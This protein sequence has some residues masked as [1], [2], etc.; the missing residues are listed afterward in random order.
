[1]GRSLTIV[2]S[3]GF[4]P[5]LAVDKIPMALF[6]DFIGGGLFRPSVVW[7]VALA[8]ARLGGHGEDELR[9]LDQRDRRILSRRRA[10]WAFRVM[11]VKFACFM[12]CSILAGLEGTVQVFRLK[13]PFPNLGEN[14]GIAGDRGF[15]DRRGCA[16]GR[17]RN[18]VLRVVGAL[19]IRVIDNGLV[20]LAH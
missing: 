16:H 4:P 6:T 5:L 8:P 3:G 10:R 17:R 13:S 14:P 20:L 18:F 1:M 11:R 19:F 9:Q 2:M 15:G 7:F 12:M